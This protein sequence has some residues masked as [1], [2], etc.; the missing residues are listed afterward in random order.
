MLI[1]Q[2]E[3]KIRVV[4]RVELDGIG[5]RRII[6]FPFPPFLFMTTLFMIPPKLHYQSQTQK[7]KNQPITRPG[8]EHCDW[9]ILPLV[10]LT[11]TI[12]FSLDR[13]RQSHRW[14]RCSA[15]D[16]VSLIFIR[17][18]RFTLLIKTLTTTP[19]LSVKWQVGRPWP[20]HDHDK[21][22][23]CEWCIAKTNKL[24]WH[25]MC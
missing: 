1:I 10:L 24:W 19:S 23:I 9:F 22:M 11:Q 12:L 2:W 21:G 5:V 25:R 14:M 7:Q 17:L 16:F 18:Y 6:T 4:S 8:N 20:Q 15:S 13:K 3:L